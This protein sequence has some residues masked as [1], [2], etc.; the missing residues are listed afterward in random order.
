MVNVTV[1]ETHPDQ[2]EPAA[3]LELDAALGDALQDVVADVVR[4]LE[5]VLVVHVLQHKLVEA[6]PLVSLAAKYPKAPPSITI[7]SALVS[8]VCSCDPK[9]V[10]LL[11]GKP[12]AGLPH[13]RSRQRPAPGCPR[14]ARAAAPSW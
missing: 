9:M 5:A 2:T 8:W 10:M 12:C 13:G 14:R 3:A 4:R 6:P 11:P 7:H 1:Q